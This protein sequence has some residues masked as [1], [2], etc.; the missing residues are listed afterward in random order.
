M[1]LVMVFIYGYAIS[2]DLN[3]INISII[4]N[5]NGELSENFI[6]AFKNNGYFSILN[7]TDNPKEKSLGILNKYEKWLKKGKISEIIIIPSDFDKK[8]KSAIQT[9]VNFIID[10]SDSNTANIIYQYSEQILN[11]FISE[12]QGLDKILKIKT[13]VYFNTEVKSSFFFIPGLIAVL[14]LM[15]SALLTSLSI[16]KERESG[17]II[18]LFISPLKSVEIIVGKTIAYILVAFTV[19]I[20]ILL[21]SRFWFEIPIRGNLFVLFL[22]SLIYIIT[23]LSLG[24]FISTAAPDQKT[25]ML[26]T[27]LA[28]M[29]PSIMLSGFIFPLESLGP[30]LQFFSKLIPATYFLKIIRGIVLK[31]ASMSHLYY[32]GLILVIM[33]VFILTIATIKFSKER[34]KVK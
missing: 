26:A 13:K 29:L 32:E 7:S 12:Y 4:N 25:A 27:L 2:Y 24:I 21:F 11:R 3:N 14:L 20:I 6:K 18:L 15:I 19:E 33:A 34:N 10:G 23:G 17:S 31:D 1:P 30:V 22:F 9:E 8:L 5:S 28:T 16:S